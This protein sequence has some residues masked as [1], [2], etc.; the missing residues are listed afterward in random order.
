MKKIRRLD[1]GIGKLG[2][3]RQDIHADYS[4]ENKTDANDTKEEK[5]P[6]RRTFGYSKRLSLA[7]TPR[8]TNNE[9][10]S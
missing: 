3:R 6:Y 9:T 4:N 5:L 8:Y 1:R 10:N 7:R 2:P